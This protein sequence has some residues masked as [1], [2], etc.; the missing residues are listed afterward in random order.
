MVAYYDYKTYAVYYFCLFPVVN[1]LLIQG[2][3]ELYNSIV[4]G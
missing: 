1:Y 3:S 2:K 4:I